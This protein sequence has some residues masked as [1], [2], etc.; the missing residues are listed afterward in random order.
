[1]GQLRAAQPD[2]SKPCCRNMDA[3]GS[4]LPIPDR[5]GQNERVMA[6]GRKNYLFAGSDDGGRRAAIM[7]YADRNRALQ[8]H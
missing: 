3:I 1:M 8:Q 5:H 7:Y 6:L 4:A 2:E